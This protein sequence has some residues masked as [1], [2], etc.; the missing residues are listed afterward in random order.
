MTARIIKPALLLGKRE[1]SLSLSHIHTQK[2]VHKL[3]VSVTHHS[4]KV[5][6]AYDNKMTTEGK[7]KDY[8]I[9][10]EEK[11]KHI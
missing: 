7:L 1:S 6:T 2:T 3:S 9:S 10:S 11:K 4:D 5:M 8:A